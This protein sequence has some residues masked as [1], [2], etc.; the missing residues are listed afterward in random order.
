MLLLNNYGM[1]AHLQ[2]IPLN[3]NTGKLKSKI[4]ALMKL[5][6]IDDPCTLMITI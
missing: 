5:M 3:E 2:K 1:K 6:L 4:A